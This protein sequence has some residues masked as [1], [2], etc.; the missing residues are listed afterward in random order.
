VLPQLLCIALELFGRFVASESVANVLAMVKT[1]HHVQYRGP[2]FSILAYQPMCIIRAERALSDLVEAA[3]T[4]SALGNEP[5]FVSTTFSSVPLCV[6]LVVL[7]TDGGPLDCSWR[8]PGLRS[9]LQV[10][11]QRNNST[12]TTSTS[13]NPSSIETSIELGQD[14]K[15]LLDVTRSS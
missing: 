4:L 15:S 11:E 3:F 7:C 12:I 1:R 5:R 8:P 13:T 2:L 14:P 10:H 6:C 9:S